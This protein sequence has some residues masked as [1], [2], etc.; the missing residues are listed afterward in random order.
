MNKALVFK[1]LKGYDLFLVTPNGAGR[2]LP[3]GKCVSGSF[4]IQTAKIGQL[5]H[6]P[7]HLVVEDDVL[8][9]AE[10]SGYRPPK[11]VVVPAV[12]SVPVVPLP[13][14][15]EEAVQS[16]IDPSAAEEEALP[17]PQ[18]AVAVDPVLTS[19]DREL[20]KMGME[21]LKMIAAT[22]GIDFPHDIK[23]KKLIALI[24]NTK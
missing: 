17:V 11:P 24:N 7:E 10:T 1:N 12:T 18:V 2:R 15:T 23:K 13:D 5:T 9:T 4:Y 21:E 8:W 19:E 14:P 16:P 6:V 20:F 3:H 22:R